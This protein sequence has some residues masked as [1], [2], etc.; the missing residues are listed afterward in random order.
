M[1][2]WISKQMIKHNT[3]FMVEEWERETRSIDSD[4]DL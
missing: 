2:D 3:H 4:S 1:L